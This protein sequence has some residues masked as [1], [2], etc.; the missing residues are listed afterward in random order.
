MKLDKKRY[1]T[2]TS[3]LAN[4]KSSRKG[5][6]ITDNTKE[7]EVLDEDGQVTWT[8]PRYGVWGEK[9]KRKPEVLETSNDLNYLQETYGPNLPVIITKLS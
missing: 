9:G 3:I 6:F 2:L 7:V 4:E 8:L 1:P 5:Q